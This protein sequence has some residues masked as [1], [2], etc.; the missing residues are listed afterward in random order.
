MT[1]VPETITHDEFLEAIE[2]LLTLLGLTSDQVLSEMHVTNAFGL[3][4][5]L[6]TIHL[7]VVAEPADP[8]TN[9]SRFMLGTSDLKPS[10][11]TTNALVWPVAV[12]VVTS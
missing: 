5:V 11:Q 3:G 4:S 1:T 7:L 8:G 12:Q 10:P 9:R 6:S 2:P